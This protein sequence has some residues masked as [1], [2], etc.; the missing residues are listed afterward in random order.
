MSARIEAVDPTGQNADSA[1]VAGEGPT[2]R[3]GIDA[4]G[5]A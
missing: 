5:P 4:E 3:R 2:M 1:G